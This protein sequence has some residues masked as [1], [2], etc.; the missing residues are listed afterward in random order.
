VVVTTF[1]GGVTVEK[2]SLVLVVVTVVNAVTDATSVEV[3]SVVTIIGSCVKVITAKNP[4][5]GGLIKSDS[6]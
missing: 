1:G 2:M 3:E 5:P 4:L 6:Y